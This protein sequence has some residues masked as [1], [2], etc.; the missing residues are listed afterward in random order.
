M[1]ITT[2]APIGVETE[3][4]FR[5]EPSWQDKIMQQITEAM[6]DGTS[7]TTLDLLYYIHERMVRTA[8]PG[9]LCR[10]K[11]KEFQAYEAKRRGIPPSISQEVWNAFDWRHAFESPCND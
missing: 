8:A 4:Q 2:E 3:K 7:E 5:A 1:H 9:H 11:L 10:V 6:V